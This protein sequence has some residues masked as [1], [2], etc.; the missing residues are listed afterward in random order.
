MIGNYIVSLLIFVSCVA[1]TVRGSFE[2]VDPNTL[3]CDPKGEIH[4][5]LPH[6]Y[7]CTKF[8]MCA[9]GEEVLFSCPAPLHFDFVL[10]TCNWADQ[11]KC[12]FRDGHEGSG[13][14]WMSDN[15][16]LPY[17]SLLTGDAVANKIRPLNIEP[18]GKSPKFDT[19][20]N[21]LRADDASRL[22]AYK[23]DCQ[24]YWH[25]VR[26]VPQTAYCSDGLYFNERTQ[27]CDFE[28]NVKC[29]VLQEDELNGEFLAIKK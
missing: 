29:S 15:A 20:L 13:E 17:G 11:T 9:H 18:P 2:G 8:F 1:R 23:G 22:V 21:C 25:C 5:L 3:S 27:Q 14:D 28:A 16:D 12:V 19:S 6:F 10:Q 26:G 4:L 7:D 24:R